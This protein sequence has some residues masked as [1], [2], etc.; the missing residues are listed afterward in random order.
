MV[1]PPL[2]RDNISSTKTIWECRSVWISDS[3]FSLVDETVK[4][5]TRHWESAHH[6]EC[7][8]KLQQVD[9]CWAVN[10][11]WHGGNTG[12]YNF[13]VHHVTHTGPTLFLYIVIGRGAA[14]NG[15]Y[16]WVSQSQKWLFWISIDPLAPITFVKF[17]RAQQACLIISQ[18]AEISTSALW[19][20]HVP[21]W[22]SLREVGHLKQWKAVSLVS[23]ESQFLCL[24]WQNKAR[25]SS[26]QNAFPESLKV[27]MET[28]MTVRNLLCILFFIKYMA[29]ATR[30][31]AHHLL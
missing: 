30:E 28:V 11:F 29:L 14:V 12:Y 15:E 3:F 25:N 13:H 24:L 23:S 20:K 26:L 5:T 7:T 1:S 19:P 31:A 22:W 9:Q 8:S 4:S 6:S 27:R 2:N 16:I 17:R 21:V 18:P 10:W